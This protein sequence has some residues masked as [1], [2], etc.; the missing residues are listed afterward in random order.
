V[1]RDLTPFGQMRRAAASGLQSIPIR[2]S[3][4]ST[5]SSISGS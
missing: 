1:N 5:S 2:A 3:P 4:T